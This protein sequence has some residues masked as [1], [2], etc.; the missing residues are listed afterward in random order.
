MLYFFRVYW[1]DLI[2]SGKNCNPDFSD[3]LG[4]GK[5]VFNCTDYKNNKWCDESG[6]QGPQWN[7]VE[8]GPL[9]KYE[10]KHGESPLVC[11]SCGCGKGISSNRFISKL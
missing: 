6:A 11:P 4:N 5:K 8:Y 9:N 10:N 7:E 1:G 2:S 3:D